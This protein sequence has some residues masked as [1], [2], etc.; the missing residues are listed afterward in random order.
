MILRPYHDWT[1]EG[2]GGAQEEEPD[3][4]R[5]VLMVMGHANSDC[6]SEASIF[7][8]LCRTGSDGPS[9]RP[10]ATTFRPSPDDRAFVAVAAARAKWDN[11]ASLLAPRH[12]TTTME[13]EY[14][15]D[16]EAQAMDIDDANYDDLPVTQE[17][18]WAVIR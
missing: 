15:Q 14:R 9:S 5:P 2:T 16:D 11:G 13:V 18:A 8:V 10:T 7:R 17:D 6:D 3:E 12:T 4:P 1:K